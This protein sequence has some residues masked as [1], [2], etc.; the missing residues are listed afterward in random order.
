MAIP[1]LSW[2]SRALLIGAGVLAV[3]WPFVSSLLRAGIEQPFELSG[4]SWLDLADPGPLLRGLFMTGTY[5][6]GT[7]IVYAMVGMV[8]GRLIMA[9][10][11]NTALRRL[12]IR[13]AAV[14]LSIAVAAWGL[15]LALAGPF[16][17][18]AALES[19]NPDL[20]SELVHTLYYGTAMGAMPSGSLW[21]LA[22]PAP[23]SGT[24]LDL[25]ITTGIAL[26]V[27]GGFL[28][29][30]TV[31]GP[32][33]SRVLE[34][35]RRAGSAPLTVYTFHVA[36]G[37]VTSLILMA[38]IEDMDFDSIPWYHSS[39]ALW[40][41]HIAGALVIGTILML[42]RRRGPLETF[43]SW[44]GRVVSQRLRRRPASD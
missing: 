7:W 9:A 28:A 18:L 26:V 34:P 37:T 39:G 40:A 42:L 36:A 10:V 24:T 6:I 16:G 17:A 19:D 15:S 20:G 30:G 43:V 5:P 3:A 29:L 44:S 1:L 41:L 13:L 33:L 25:A 12:G 8:V 14:G 11:D 32:R 4:A 23:H 2:S 38:N 31:L 35:I 22:S 21:W 27:L